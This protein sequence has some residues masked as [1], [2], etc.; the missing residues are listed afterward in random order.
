M[1]SPRPVFIVGSPRS[2]TS[3]CTWA[4]GQHSNILPL[5]E[6]VWL[7]R[8]A[9]DLCVAHAI[10]SSRGERSH[11]SASGITREEMC[12][13][14]GRALHKLVISHRSVT[15]TAEGHEAF[16]LTRSGGD[17]KRRWVDG[18]PENSLWIPA[19]RALFPRAQFVHLARDVGAVARSL[20]KFSTVGA[21]DK[22]VEFGYRKWLRC[23][24]ACADAERAYGPGVV[25]RVRYDD[26][27]N[28][29]KP[30]LRRIL[31]F[32]GEEYE[33]ACA[34]PLR[35]RINSSQVP[36]EHDINVDEVDP[37][38]VADAE[39]LS[40]ALQHDKPVSVA[41]PAVAAALE[42]AL[43][44]R[45]RFVGSLE[46]ERKRALEALASLRARVDLE[47]LDHIRSVLRGVLIIP[48]AV[49]V[50]SKGADDILEA[51]RELGRR[52]LHCPADSQGDWTGHHPADTSDAIANVVEAAAAGASYL[53]IPWS[54]GWWLDH[55]DGLRAHLTQHGRVAWRDERCTVY[56]LTSVPAL[57]A[58]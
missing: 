15:S 25:L 1:S 42:D 57:A 50:V 56:E 12:A 14:V 37:A 28:K 13:T 11:L 3:V 46:Q 31:L 27:V 7:P 24:S 4:L 10:G 8:V 48:G 2:G 22:T 33:P 26:L 38:L 21:D 45:I 17:P 41:D 39:A 47:S 16:Q 44:Q 34:E 51:V 53:V 9:V 6:T 52:A 29:P 18:T 32:L 23:T 54:C 49:A 58:R 30:T 20:T 55:Y 35:V 19:L 5:E 43:A 36:A 40:L